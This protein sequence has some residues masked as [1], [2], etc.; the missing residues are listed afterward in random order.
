M[1]QVEISNIEEIHDGVYVL[2]MPKLFDF[3]AGQIISVSVNEIHPRLYSICSGINENCLRILFD[4]KPFGELTNKLSKLSR[5][6][7]IFIS[8]PSGNFRC[9]NAPAYWIANG[10]GIAPFYSMLLSGLGDNKT[11][12]YGGKNSG[13]F[14]FND[15]FIKRLKNKYIRCC[16]REEVPNTYFGR[17]T[18]FLK[19]QEI[20][21]ATQNYYL[22]GSSEMVVETRDIL[23]SKGIPYYQIFAEIYF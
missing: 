12:I 16:S 1:K 5:G 8:N 15:T 11:L 3:T 18:T 21:P 4:V 7:K 10:T 13:S 23:L 6:D 2:E 17:L 20:L 22:C 9:D 19:D 14:Y